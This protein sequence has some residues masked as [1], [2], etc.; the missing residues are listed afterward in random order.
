[1]TSRAEHTQP[2]VRYAEM[3]GVDHRDRETR[4]RFVRF[5][6]DDVRALREIAGGAEAGVDE[7]VED[8]YRNLLQFD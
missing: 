6:A 7:V 1:M 2:S 8:F 4:K 5:G 3:L